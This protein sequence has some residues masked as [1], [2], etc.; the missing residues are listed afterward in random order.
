MVN[1]SGVNGFNIQKA[2][3]LFKEREQQNL[4]KEKPVLSSD[5]LSGMGADI[6]MNNIDSSYLTEENKQRLKQYQSEEAPAGITIEPTSDYTDMP[7]VAE[8]YDPA[9]Q[10][11]EINKDP[12]ITAAP[13]DEPSSA[14]VSEVPP[15]EIVEE[16]PVVEEEPIENTKGHRP[17][18]PVGN[19]EGVPVFT[20]PQEFQNWIEQQSQ[21]EVDGVIGQEEI[22]AAINSFREAGTTSVRIGDRTYQLYLDETGEGVQTGDEDSIVLTIGGD[23]T[24][25]AGDDIVIAYNVGD[26]N[27]NDGDDTVILAGAG[28]NGYT[29]EG[30]VV[31]TGNGNDRVSVNTDSFIYLHTNAG[32]DTIDV[33]SSDN[34][35]VADDGNDTINLYG[36]SNNVSA[37]SANPYGQDNDTVNVYGDANMIRTGA[38][39]DTFYLYDNGSVDSE[40]NLYNNNTVMGEGDDDTYYVYAEGNELYGGEG[41]DTYI[42][43]G[44]LSDEAFN[45]QI[46]DTAVNPGP[47]A[48]GGGG[49]CSGS[50]GC[51]ST[52]ATS[53]VST[54]TQ[55][56][57]NS[58]KLGDMVN[59]PVSI[60]VIL[61]KASG[62]EVPEGIDTQ[63][64]LKAFLTT[65]FG[66]EAFD[67]LPEDIQNEI[68]KYLGLPMTQN[69]ELVPIEGEEGMPCQF[70][71]DGLAT[72][73]VEV[74]EGTDTPEEWQAFLTEYSASEGFSALPEEQ[75]KAI[76]EY[77]GSFEVAETD[78]PVEEETET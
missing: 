68:R 28:R 6:S 39:N 59:N 64:E 32:D 62:I 7:I 8:D 75:K 54:E 44:G 38:G 73:G 26:I 24:T 74:P 13:I 53:T 1:F 35:I 17:T 52:G 14:P 66:T 16:E 55:S 10:S 48:C 69:D 22:L 4:E 71:Q 19:D 61:L 29:D 67:E 72:A 12:Q 5:L 47:T 45:A 58:R 70:I 50:G 40:G 30:G 46:K 43:A 65:L 20:D 23:V 18:G 11:P 15:T 76:T 3:D 2:K 21:G 51:S 25:G 57:L 33:F 77:L 78:P 9:T 56:V 41:G 37:G 36:N 49:G 60:T 31:N 34:S 27:T 63:A 42:N